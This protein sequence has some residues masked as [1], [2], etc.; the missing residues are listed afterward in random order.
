M[1]AVVSGEYGLGWEG[2]GNVLFLSC[3]ILFFSVMD[4]YYFWKTFLK[5]QSRKLEF[6]WKPPGSMA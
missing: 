4:K 3:A 6:Y 1:Q 5:E 2:K